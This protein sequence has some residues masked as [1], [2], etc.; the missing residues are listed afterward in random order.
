MAFP[1]PEREPHRRASLW[2]AETRVPDALTFGN[3]FQG[4]RIP[5]AGGVDATQKAAKM[6]GQGHQDGG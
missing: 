2:D 5:S 1:L 3:Y 4:N 6:A